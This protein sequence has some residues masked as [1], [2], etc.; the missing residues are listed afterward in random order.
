MQNSFDA[1]HDEISEIIGYDADWDYESGEPEPKASLHIIKADVDEIKWVQEE[2]GKLLTSIIEKIDA[3]GNGSSSD[4]PGYSARPAE[5]PPATISGATETAPVSESASAELMRVAIR[6]AI[7][8]EFNGLRDEV[9][10]YGHEVKQFCEHL[11]EV[12]FGR[13]PAGPKY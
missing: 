1:L 7:E 6:D 9:L 2:Q 4:T 11:S 10:K 13:D 3:H 5:A 12:S 8:K